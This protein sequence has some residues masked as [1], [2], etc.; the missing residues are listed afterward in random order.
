MPALTQIL[1][2]NLRNSS[3]SQS[4][5][6]VNCDIQLIIAYYWHSAHLFDLD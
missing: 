1:S 5:K 6:T 2:Q 4:I 3:I